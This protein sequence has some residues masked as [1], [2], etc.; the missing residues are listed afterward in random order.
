MLVRGI[1]IRDI[2]AIQEV[3]IRKVLSLLVNSH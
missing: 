1:G 2:S 3:S